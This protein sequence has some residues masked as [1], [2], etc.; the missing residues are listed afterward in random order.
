[1]GGEPW[2]AA[3]ILRWDGDA[4][5]TH[6]IL[7]SHKAVLLGIWCHGQRARRTTVSRE[8]K[9]SHARK[10]LSLF[11]FPNL[12]GACMCAGTALHDEREWW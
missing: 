4:H 1:L 3:K 8:S 5:D 7:S 11:P 6:I 12:L 9:L 10:L 2:R